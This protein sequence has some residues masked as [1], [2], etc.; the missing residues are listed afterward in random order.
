[1]KAKSWQSQTVSE[2]KLI[3]PTLAQQFL[4]EP[5]ERMIGATALAIPWITVTTNDTAC[6]SPVTRHSTFQRRRWN[7]H[8]WGKKAGSWSDTCLGLPFQKQRPLRIES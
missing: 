8:D 5:P 2:T 4:A 3:E 1:L 6:N 7:A